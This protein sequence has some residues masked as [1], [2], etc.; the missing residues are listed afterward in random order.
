METGKD[1]GGG[2]RLRSGWMETASGSGTR[3]EVESWDFGDGE[4][5]KR[6]GGRSEELKEGCDW[7]KLCVGEVLVVPEA[8]EARS[9]RGFCEKSGMTG[10]ESCGHG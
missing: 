9:S 6:L 10:G 7:E 8:L 2:E 3:R 5:T 1:E 4:G